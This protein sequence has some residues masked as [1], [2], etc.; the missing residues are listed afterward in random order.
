MIHSIHLN[1]LQFSFSLYRQK[2][3][4]PLIT[5]HGIWDIREGIIIRLQDLEKNE[6][7]GEIAPLPWFGSETLTEAENFCEKLNGKINLD[8][9]NQIPD[10]L[11]CCQFAFQSAFQDLK[12]KQ[13]SQ[14]SQIKTNLPHLEY[15]YLLPTGEKALIYLQNQQTITP[16]TFKWKIAVNSL[17]K[18]Q[19]WFKELI[20][21]LPGKSKLRLDAN[22]GLTYSQAQKWLEITSTSK[23]VE[24][25]EQPLPS[26]QLNLMLDLL[27][28]YSTSLALDESVANL[29]QLQDCYEKGWQGIFVIKPPIAG[30][31]YKLKEFCLKHKLDVVISSVLETTIG[32]KISLGLAEQI[33]NPNRAVG[34]GV[35]HWFEKELII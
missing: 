16:K 13:I 9:I 29:K 2:F 32:R 23:I 17:E 20:T 30:Y 24:F 12:V 28:I 7:L 18:E 35:N 15:S 1:Y 31:P 4:Q 26:N 10:D 33:H 3:K 11:P 5:N 6:G 8:I 14:D 22:G 27:E 21:L 25:I 34:F 19:R